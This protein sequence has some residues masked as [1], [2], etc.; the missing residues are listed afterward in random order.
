MANIQHNGG[1]PILTSEVGFSQVKYFETTV[2]GTA[3]T[4]SIDPPA[5][6]LILRNTDSTDG[7][8]LR[9][10]G[11]EATTSV[12]AIPGDNIKIGPQGIFTMDFDSLSTISIIS[13][14]TA[15][16]EGILGFKG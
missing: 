12:S 11:E 15:V 7:V 5:K 4:L 2:G 3:F 10:D 9:I 13:S 1:L 16:V 6:R 8:F 14:G